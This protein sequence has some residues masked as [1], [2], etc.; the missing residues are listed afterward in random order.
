M[1]DSNTSISPSPINN[2]KKARQSAK[3]IDFTVDAI[4][5]IEPPTTVDRVEYKDSKEQGL[6]LRVTKNGVKTFT[7]VGRAKGA[8]KAERKT[9]GKFPIVKP[10]EARK[11]ARELSGHQASGA[12]VSAEGRA[13][14]QEMRLSDL[15]ALYY[16]HLSATKKRPDISEMAWR[17]Y[18]SP[19]FGNRRLSDIS[20]SEVER[21]HRDLP[22]AILERRDAAAAELLAKRKQK[23]A[24][25]EAR[26]L[27]RKHGPLPKLDK[28]VKASTSKMV[29]NGNSAANRCVEVM[30]AMYN[31]ALEQK[32]NLYTGKNPAAE[33]T[34][35]K[36]N[37]RSRFIQSDEL[38]KFFTAL[39]GIS[40]QTVRD[41][42]LTSLLTAARKE[43]VISMKW[44]DIHLQRKEWALPGEFQKNGAP[45]IVPL[46]SELVALL[47]QRK[48]AHD[49][50]IAQHPPKTKHDKLC[51]SFVFP[52]ARSETGHIVNMNKV[53]AT[54]KENA[55]IDDLRLHDLRRTMGSWQA[56]TG[57]SLVVIGKSLNHKDPTATAIYARLD[58]DPVRDSM[59]TATSAMFEA[60][61][62]KPKGEVIDM[63]VKSQRKAG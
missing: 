54:L 12:S 55:K 15:W 60:A 52:S 2:P 44:E 28:A 8:A 22:A 42:I 11:M 50:F 33:Q 5:G 10:A 51:A 49:E 6:Y 18:I 39:A 14:R 56:K 24:E 41:A 45:Y 57:A 26:R 58:M 47:E 29:I 31:F 23:E 46:V 20:Y 38:S 36:E 17:I 9:L 7:Y 43:N 62:L 61:G 37:E 19:K 35:F 63:P 25:K 53:W 1:T 3:E 34:A 27:I 59:T 40:S 32:R 48:E 4:Q 16:E 30:R 21:W 13:R